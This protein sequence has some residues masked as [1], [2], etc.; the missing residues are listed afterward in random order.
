MTI[1][2]GVLYHEDGKVTPRF[3]R[4]AE[5]IAELFAESFRELAR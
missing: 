4:Q 2:P 1:R 5:E 3:R